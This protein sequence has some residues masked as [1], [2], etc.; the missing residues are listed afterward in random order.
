L[1]AAGL[2][3]G[4]SILLDPLDAD[5]T[6]RTA[7]GLTAL[8]VQV[9]LLPGAWRVHGRGARIPG[10][11]AVLLGDSGT[12]ARFLLAVA[13]LGRAPSRLE[14]S[15]RLSARPMNDLAR[16]LRSLGAQVRSVDPAREL[17]LEAGGSPA[18]GG[19][20]RVDAASTSQFASA[21][22]LVAPVLPAGL[23]LALEPPVVSL[24][25]VDLT[26][27]VM[28]DFGVRVGR[29]QPL[30]FQ[31]PQAEYAARS[32]PIE[33]DHSSASYFL[34]AAALVGGTVRVEGLLPG[35]TQPD[36]QLARIL[37]RLGCTV[38]SGERWLE[39]E[40]NGRIP[41]FECDLAECPDLAPTLAAVALFAEGPCILRGVAHLRFK[42]SDR[43]DMLARNLS[44]LG[45]DATARGDRLEIG[46]S[47]SA[48]PRAAIVATASDHRI[49]MAFAVAG[50]RADGIAIDDAACVAKS[51]PRFWEDFARLEMPAA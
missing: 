39:V 25:Y 21:L 37:A 26:L 18:R 34:A 27:A 48:P 14:G 3:S 7:A 20:L 8:G 38:R 29:P 44:A 5:D 9:D 50:L 42:E 51:Y 35:S 13:S 2:A 17:P 43:L 32:Y 28:A 45:R 1:I 6:R 16:A 22:L 15:A 19:P 47:R 12:S 49:A 41:P 10:G 24:P 40:G 31:V 46:A 30:R 36:A 33:G 23:D 11:A 4:E